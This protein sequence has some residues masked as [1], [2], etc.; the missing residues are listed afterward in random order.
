MSGI[1]SVSGLVLQFACVLFMSAYIWLNVIG[2]DSDIDSKN[3]LIMQAVRTTMILALVFILLPCFL[4]YTQSVT[5]E[6]ARASHNYSI[7]AI[8]WLVVIFECGVAILISVFSKSGD[9]RELISAIR[10][11]FRRALIG[12]ILSMVLSWLLS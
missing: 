7:A 1:L 2:K 11:A 10:K 5:Q 3:T 4:T 9:K 6:I 8:S 12:T